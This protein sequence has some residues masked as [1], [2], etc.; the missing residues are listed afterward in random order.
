MMDDKL[1]SLCEQVLALGK[2]LGADEMEV[3]VSKR[4]E[5]SV[6][7][8]QGEV[9]KLVDAGGRSLSF[10]LIIDKKTASAST[11][12]LSADVVEALVKSA[13]D[14]ACL[15]SAD[16]FAGLPDQFSSPENRPDLELYDPQVAEMQPEDKIKTAKQ[17]EAL[18]LADPRITHSHGSSFFTV[19]GQAL[20]MNSKGFT[21]SYP[22]STVGSG[23]YLQAGEG[24][25]L[26][27][28]G[29]YDQARFLNDLWSEQRIA[30]KAVHR[31]TRLLG[32]R[33]VK[34]QRVPVIC[35]AS[36][37]SALLGYLARCVS[38]DGIYLKQSFLAGKL[39]DEIA[40]KNIHIIDDPRIPRGPG[41]RPYDSEGTA[42]RR[43]PIV[44]NG[45]LMNYLL[46]TYSA[47]KLDLH[48][49][50]HAS[51]PSNFFLERGPAPLSEMIAGLDKGLLLTGFLGQGFNPM[52]GDL[53]RGAFG[54]WIEKGE[55]V[56]PVAEITVSGNLA[57]IL[58]QIQAVGDDLELRR[59][60]SGP[61]IQI[62]EM[63]VSG[64]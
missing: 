8:L 21:G 24:A 28:E 31:A 9:E 32:A 19:V 25:G 42:S 12:D 50:G 37:T 15:A 58:M 30:E 5:F 53:S 60:L 48:S 18:C 59:S 3:A 35:E 1:R 14:R 17:I 39:G 51:G 55:V 22:V 23:V 7:V 41:S 49:T 57:D 27:D 26:I 54:L 64:T 38:G 29:W 45:R 11:S 46:D 44:E 56:H 63:T 33:K 4:R 43:L 20:L 34:T 52:T 62:A 6:E 2:K 61:A 40:A 13:V 16:P 10:E 36:V 47:R